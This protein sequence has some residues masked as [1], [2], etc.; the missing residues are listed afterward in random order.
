MIISIIMTKIEGKVRRE[1]MMTIKV[2]TVTTATI[3][4][5]W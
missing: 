2:I 5:K 3:I 1:K 4:M